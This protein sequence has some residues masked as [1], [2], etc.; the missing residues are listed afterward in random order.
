VPFRNRNFLGQR[1]GAHHVLR[2]SCR[3]PRL[4]VEAH[5]I[6]QAGAA[7]PGRR[8]AGRPSGKLHPS[9]AARGFSARH[10]RSDRF[11][12]CWTC[13]FVGIFKCSKALRFQSC[14]AG[15][16]ACCAPTNPEP[17]ASTPRAISAR[18]FRGPALRRRAFSSSRRWRP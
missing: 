10:A 18:P 13:D 14:L 8:R 9:R 3:D 1:R 17:A 16:A 4:S 11:S 7:A 15:D 6:R 5:G 12:R 2:R